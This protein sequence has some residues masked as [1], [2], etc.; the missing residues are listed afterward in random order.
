MKGPHTDAT[1]ARIAALPRYGDGTGLHRMR[2]LA[3]DVT[4]PGWLTR[5]E[6]LRVTGS[7]GKGSVAAL[8]TALL[9]GLGLRTGRF[10]SPHLRHLAE[11][12]QIAGAAIDRARL[13]EHVERVCARAA[14]YEAMHANDRFG[15]FEVC[16]AVALA[17]FAAEGVEAPVLEAGI[18]GRFDST[19]VAAGAVVAL[20]AVER[21]HT[22]LLG[23]TPLQ[24]A[25][26]KADL[27][28]AGGTLVVGRL[29]GELRRRLAGYCAVRGVELVSVEEIAAVRDV[30]IDGRHMGFDLTVDGVDFGRVECGLIGLHQA[31]NAALAVAIVGRWLRRTGRAIDPARW[32][33]AVR[34]ALPAV[35]WPGRFEVIADDPTVVIDVGHTPGSARATV[36]TLRAAYPG[37]RVVLLTGVSANKDAAG[38]MAALVP[39]ADEVICTRAHHRG[40][41]PAALAQLCERVRAGA[42]S[43][44]EGSL[45]A[46]LDHAVARAAATDALVL[47]TGGLFLA[48]EA[49]VLLDGGDPQRLWFF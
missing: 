23:D 22:Q 36:E 12:F 47:I 3:L 16:A 41:D 46:A 4:P 25:C 42:V 31:W 8:T 21:E 19:R 13:A 44:V 1:V 11:R 37:R 34:A 30:R 9:D 18:G 2:A 24:I 27:C 28:P 40:G 29:D 38:I 20:T 5:T 39:A 49:A 14:A 10:T 7:K 35:R 17:C 43:R 45:R 15:A 32:V 33:A 6:T 48:V 26:D